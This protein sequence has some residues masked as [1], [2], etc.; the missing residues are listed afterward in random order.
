MSR[1]LI[2][3]SLIALVASACATT[4]EEEPVEETPVVQ[5]TPEPVQVA[6]PVPAAPA[7]EPEPVAQPMRMLPETASPLP[8]VGLAGMG[9]IGLAGALRGIRRWL[10]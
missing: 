2:V 10:L 8:L 1:I 9:A 7:P 3:L 6:E 4:S 5:A